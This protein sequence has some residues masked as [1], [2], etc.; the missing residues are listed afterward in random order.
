M[1]KKNKLILTKETWWGAEGSLGGR[2]SHTDI[3]SFTNHP[4]AA[5]GVLLGCALLT[6][7]P[8][9]PCSSS[10]SSLYYF[11]PPD[12]ETSPPTM[13]K[14]LCRLSPLTFSWSGRTGSSFFILNAGAVP[15]GHPFRS[16][17]F[18]SSSLRGFQLRLLHVSQQPALPLSTR[19]IHFNFC[20]FCR[21]QHSRRTVLWDGDV[22][23]ARRP[24]LGVTR[25][26]AARRGCCGAKMDWVLLIK[27][28]LQISAC[29]GGY[30]IKPPRPCF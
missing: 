6:W 8:A 9:A 17:S 30:V 3:S 11:F 5:C 12:C 20:V 10:P 26:R 13:P 16:G 28:V 24:P 21:P 15:D 2:V 23:G 1:W 18:M 22:A 25:C 4:Q 29:S 7:S 27:A 14:F 19:R